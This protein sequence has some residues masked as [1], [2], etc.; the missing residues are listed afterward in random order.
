[1]TKNEGTIDRL[2]RGVII[3][4]VALILALSASARLPACFSRSWALS[5]P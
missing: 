1:M 2:L 3:A 5:W 4:P